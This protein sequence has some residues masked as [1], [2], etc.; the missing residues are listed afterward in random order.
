[1]KMNMHTKSCL[2]KLKAQC[3]HHL[4]TDAYKPWDS[5]GTVQRRSYLD[6][7]APLAREAL[8][9]WVDEVILQSI[10]Q[11]GPDSHPRN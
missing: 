9:M 10:H 7:T 6:R 3:S 8:Q 1:M 4:H 11:S 2:S 5:N